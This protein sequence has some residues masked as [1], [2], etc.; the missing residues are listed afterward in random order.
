MKTLYFVCLL[1]LTTAC[2]TT[3]DSTQHSTIIQVIHGTSFGKCRGYCTK[4]LTYAQKHVEYSQ[5]S[6][7]DKQFPTKDS[8][9]AFSK[10]EWNTLLE[11]AA[12][13]DFA[14]LPETIGCPDC[15]D[16][17]AEYIEIKQNSATKRITFE[18]SQHVPELGNLLTQLRNMKLRILKEE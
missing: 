14:S 7:D 16:G 4:E 5:R 17:G 13:I 15:A 3:S 9:I 6:R 11:A 10:T 18:F 1:L 8:I 2:K 12:S